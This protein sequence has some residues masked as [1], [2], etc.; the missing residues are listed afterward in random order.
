MDEQ[1]VRQAVCRAAHELW[2]R[3][4]VAGDDGL[5]CVELNR[6][7]YVI[8]PPGVRKADAQPHQTRDVDLDGESVGQARPGGRPAVPPSY[9][10][11][12]SAALR[13]SARS[14]ED[15]RGD[16]PIVRACIIAQPVTLLALL[17]RAGE[18]DHVA[19]ASG[20][21]IPVI[22]PADEERITDTIGE[23]P[24]ILLRGVGLFVPAA[25]LD[26]ALNRV[27][28]LEHDAAI[29]RAAQ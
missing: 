6:R 18:Q 25:S 14:A 19:L 28:R 20:R 11:P 27:E 21:A 9:W 15:P 4:L 16:G 24:G 12:C 17:H 22:D 23:A 29:T 1:L 2:L 13:L 5:V 7:R 26:R 8:A 3:G 10:R